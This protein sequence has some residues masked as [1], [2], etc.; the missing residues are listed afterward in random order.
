M[1]TCIFSF[2]VFIFKINTGTLENKQYW[3]QLQKWTSLA[4]LQMG[5]LTDILTE[6]FHADAEIYVIFNKNKIIY[7]VLWPAS[8][9][10][11]FLYIR[12]L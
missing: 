9:K 11:Y 4:R 8:L 10:K 5:F 3:K 12:F 6:I 1:Y 7:I 2:L